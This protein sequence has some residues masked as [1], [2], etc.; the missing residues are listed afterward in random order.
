ML[1]VLTAGMMS[2]L[3]DFRIPA[4]AR[5]TSEQVW[6]SSASATSVLNTAKRSAPRAD[7]QVGSSSHTFLSEEL[8]NY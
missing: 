3:A 8:M 4:A 7:E 6:L 5:V 1:S 2:E